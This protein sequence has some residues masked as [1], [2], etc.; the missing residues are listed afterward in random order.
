MDPSEFL[1]NVVRPNLVRLEDS[2]IFDLF[3]RARFKTNNIIYT[4]GE[5]K[6]PGNISFMDYL[7]KGTERLHATAGRYE[8]PEEHPFFPDDLPPAIIQRDIE[9]LPF[10]L[11]KNNINANPT[12]RVMHLNAIKRICEDG[13]D[14]HYGSTA[15][16]DISLLQD[17]S[18]R[19]HYGLIVAETKFQQDPEEY[20]ELI[21]E[22]NIDGITSKLKNQKVED[23]ILERVRKKGEKFGVNSQFIKEFYQD[24]IIPLTIA[25]EIEYFLIRN[26]SV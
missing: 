25:I 19:I 23:Q 13:D 1:E 22:K 18:R 26:Q 14:K 6:V 16:Q 9:R 12:I 3:E 10:P 5:I 20:S 15:L 7:L 11:A 8:H 2:I 4:P 21:E 24:E 17:L